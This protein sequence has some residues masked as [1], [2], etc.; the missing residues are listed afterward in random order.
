MY[1]FLTASLREIIIIPR[2]AIKSHFFTNEQNDGFHL[3]WNLK[4]KK[5]SNVWFQMNDNVF[6]VSKFDVY[7]NDTDMDMDLKDSIRKII[8]QCVDNGNKYKCNLRNL[9][10]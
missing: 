10:I 9:R 4:H 2:N 1:N 8:R 7:L 5:I 3:K 6:D